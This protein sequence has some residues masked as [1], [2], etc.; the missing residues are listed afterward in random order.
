MTISNNSKREMAA[1]Q[2]GPFEDLTIQDAFTIIAVCVARM[3]YEDSAIDVKRI[4]AIAESRPEFIEERKYIVSRIN[5]YVNSLP[6]VDLQ[7]AVE[8]AADALKSPGLSEAAFEFA[9]EVLLQGMVLTDKKKAIL[10]SIATY[11]SID[12][13]FAQKIIEK[14]T[15]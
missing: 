7:K 14:V 9:S 10:D 6:T 15:G 4:E 13:Y 12:H 11:L 5:R 8:I 3:D 1:Y 2:K